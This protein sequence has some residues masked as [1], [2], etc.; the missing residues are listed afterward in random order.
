MRTPFR[1]VFLCLFLATAAPLAAQTFVFDLRGSQEVPPVPSTATGGCMIELDQVMAQSTITCVHDVMG[2]TVMHIHRGA[3][4]VNGPI[5][6][7]LGDPASPVTATWIGVTAAD[8]SD[9]LAGNLYVNI[10]TAGRP[11]GEIRGQ[12]LPRTIDTVSFT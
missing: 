11:A 4:G 3:P 2:A 7:D 10:H 5:V 12:I 1:S 9:M 8:I 6:F